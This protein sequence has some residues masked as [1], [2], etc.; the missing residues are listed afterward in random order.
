M[1]IPVLLEEVIKILDPHPGEFGID[2][3]VGGGGHAKEL[4]KKLFPQGKLL[5][6]D[7]DEGAVKSARATL[8][9]SDIK[10]IDVVS[11]FVQLQ[12]VMKKK[13]L[14]KA[15]WALFDFGFSSN[16]IEDGKRGL[17]LYNDGPLDMRLH[18]SNSSITAASLVNTLRKE[19]LAALFRECG[20]ER[21][22]SR[23]AEQI[24]VLRHRRTI[25]TTREL[26]KLVENAVPRRLW[27][28]KIHPATK[29]FQA[30]RI[31]VND[32]LQNIE[33]MF[34]I[35]PNVIARGG[36]VACITF[37]SLEDRIVKR[38]FKLFA[39][40]GKAELLTKKPIIPTRAEMLHNPRSR[41]AKLRAIRFI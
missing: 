32:E 23:I 9:S 28:R 25:T 24:D 26:A 37:H 5:I 39:T 15:N 3:T 8:E 33:K 35:L 22:A 40:T 27:P 6:I 30:L 19:E 1:H 14:R 16:Q 12:A 4:A 2:A 10:V 13:K 11:N 18:S 31:A 20:G 29:I 41:S 36:R 21:F 34:S 7:W 38:Y 17:S